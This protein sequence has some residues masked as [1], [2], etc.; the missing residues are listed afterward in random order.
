MK[1]LEMLSRKRLTGNLGEDSAVKFLKKKGY[2]ILKRNFVAGG[3][4]I[5]VIA[6]CPDTIVFAEV[7]TRLV[8]HQHMKEPRPACSV[9]PKK[10]RSIISAARCYLAKAT[11]KK[12][13]RFDCIEV[14][15][16][17]DGE[18]DSVREINHI[19]G[20]FNFDTA[21]RK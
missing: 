11:P 16:A 12:Q 17:N 6:E 19:E 14:F 5:D 4:E 21:Y 3:K 13:V 20:A 10:Q 1:I 7:K 2:K 8:S 15:L 18:R 9:T